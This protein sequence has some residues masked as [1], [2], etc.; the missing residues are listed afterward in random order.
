MHT[1]SGKLILSM[2][3]C[4]SYGRC[5]GGQLCAS[6]YRLYATDEGEEEVSFR[7]K[8]NKGMEWAAECMMTNCVSRKNIVHWQWSVDV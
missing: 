4:R 7:P 6:V 2:V 8:S 5:W 3:S 1:L